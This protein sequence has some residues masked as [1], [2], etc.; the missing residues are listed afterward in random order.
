MEQLQ[1]MK[2][3]PPALSTRQVQIV[4]LIAEGRRTP[5]IARVLGLAEKTVYNHR[6]HIALKLGSSSVA[7][8]T[9]WAIRKNLVQ[10]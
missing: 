9:R 2:R 8:I 6:Q 1:L 10:P 5:E 3:V 4:R 7:V